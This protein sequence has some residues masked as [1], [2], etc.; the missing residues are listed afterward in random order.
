MDYLHVLIAGTSPDHSLVSHAELDLHVLGLT[1][2]VWGLE[3]PPYFGGTAGL[4]WGL[5]APPYFG[6][7]AG[8]VWGLE[9]PPY[10]GGTAGLVWGLEVPPYLVRTT[11]FVWWGPEF[12]SCIECLVG[13]SEVVRSSHIPP[14]YLADLVEML[15]SAGNNHLLQNLVTAEQSALEVAIDPLVEIH[16]GPFHIAI[17]PLAECHS[18]PFHVA[19]LVILLVHFLWWV[20]LC[21]SAT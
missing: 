7:T 10:F 13:V 14:K 20:E 2:F 3:V 5:E 19:S 8:F 11:G 4:V 6:G 9:V 16:S 21:A 15:Y 18:G 17:D 1:G 12:H